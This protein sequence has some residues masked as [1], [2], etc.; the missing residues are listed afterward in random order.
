[1]DSP[2]N[3]GVQSDQMLADENMRSYMRAQEA[4]RSTFVT[5]ADKYRRFARGDQWNPADIAKLEAAG[6]PAVTINLIKPTINAIKGEYSNRRADFEYKPRYDGATEEV[7]RTLTKLAMAICD[8]NDYDFVESEVFDDAIHTGEGYFDIRMDFED[9]ILGE[10]RITSEDPA[11]VWVDP[12]AR[13]YDPRKWGECGTARWR[14]I[15][16]IEQLYGKEKATQ[17]RVAAVLSNFSSDSFRYDQPKNQFGD[18]HRAMEVGALTDVSD[19]QGR[20]LK[21]VLVI[22]R[23]WYTLHMGREFV[24][25]QF[26]DTREVPESWDQEKAQAFAQRMGLVIRK[27]MRRRIKWRTTAGNVVLHDDWSPYKTFTIIPMFCY[28]SRGKATGVVQD[29]ISPQEITNKT[30]SQMLH[31]V[32]T[33]ANSGWKVPA[34]ALVN[35]TVDDLARRGA[36]TGLVLEYNVAIGEPE[37]IQPNSVPTGL[38]NVANRA[39]SSFREISGV[40]QAMLGLEP[41]RVSG[42]A[43]ENKQLRGSVQLQPVLDNLTYTR[44]L[45]GRKILELVQDFYTEER[46]IYISD[47]AEQKTEELVINQR[48]AAGT[49]VNDL[50]LGEYSVM[51]SSQPARDNYNESQFAQVLQMRE[52]GIPVP[53][54]FAIRYSGL[55]RKGEIADI[56]AQLEGF[57]EPSPMQQK[58]EELQLKLIEAELHELY[59]DVGVKEATAQLTLAKART[60]ADKPMLER[61]KLE[62]EANTVA[63]EQ[64]TRD[65]VQ[66]LKDMSSI[67]QSMQS[68]RVKLQT[69]AIQAM[70][71]E[72]QANRPATGGDKR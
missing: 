68:N 63:L 9:N 46:I 65:R 70:A 34:G 22:E 48:L 55:Q 62:Q 59:A 14:S 38:D 39:I 4:G 7:A 69:A 29:L 67:V 32:N 64:T 42:V 23:Q 43:L 56:V 19:A 18:V 52:L 16:E 6:R 27:V 28:W 13:D 50:T 53:G 10:V 40:N 47:R 71:K 33:T 11:E 58:M 36:E 44:V 20:I 60:E 8:S 35:M 66:R 45:V 24:S 49:I 15:D 31:V 61:E 17:L 51:V 54:H 21:S 41:A 2:A 30:E 37:K 3:A 25:L 12:S 1:M 5:N 72:K 57:G 26:G